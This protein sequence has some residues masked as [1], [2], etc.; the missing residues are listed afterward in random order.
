[1]T[2]AVWANPWQTRTS[3]GEP[4]DALD[5]SNRQPANWCTR[6]QEQPSALS[7]RAAVAKVLVQR[8]ANVGRQR[9]MLLTP[10]LA[11][12]HEF[13]PPP[14]N[15]AQFEARHLAGTQSQTREQLEDRVITAAGCRASITA[16]QQQPD[17]LCIQSTRKR[18]SLPVR[19]GWY[20]RR[21]LRR[22]PACH[23]RKP[24][25]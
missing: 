19:H 12:N 14:A 23:V 2:E 10:A 16:F 3:T 17:P 18:A 24:Q 7:P 4:D 6:S 13:A 9:Q 22:R 1:M 20:C 21:Q 15:V 11:A 8:L 5:G 25:Q